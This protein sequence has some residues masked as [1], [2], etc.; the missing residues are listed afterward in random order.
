MPPG[1]H[2]DLLAFL[3]RLYSA[4][5]SRPLASLNR[6]SHA[7]TDVPAVLSR[8]RLSK[9]LNG[10]PKELLDKVYVESFVGLITTRQTDFEEF[11]SLWL[12]FH[13]HHNEF[14]GAAKDLR[15]RW[16]GVLPMDLVLSAHYAK[17]A[18]TRGVS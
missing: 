18:L 16:T 3:Y 10:D 12:A 9:I 11:E 17:H 14:G 7:T 2:R 5:G 13:N 15:G 8:D 1:P 4:D 6:A